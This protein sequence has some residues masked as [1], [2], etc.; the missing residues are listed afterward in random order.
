MAEIYWSCLIGGVIFTIV[1]LLVG[2]LIGGH[3]DVGHPD[4]A[5]HDVGGHGHGW[6]LDFLKPAVII[7]AITAFGGAGV[8]LLKYSTLSSS[9]ITSVAVSIAVVTGAAVY[10]L[11]IKPLRNAESSIG[12][13]MTDLVGRPC[14]VVV[15][16]PETG[17]GE[18]IVSIGNGLANHIAS[19][20]GVA[21]PRGT[22]AVVVE[23][24]QGVLVVAR[25][26]LGPPSSQ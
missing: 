3:G 13:S 22:E 1:A 20:D 15:P 7:G 16:I 5:G 23:V 2:D 19:A 25:L 17:Y 11:Y 24:E 4:T 10:L 18:V 6:H 21:L 8:M 12:Y 26:E 9:W 14:Q